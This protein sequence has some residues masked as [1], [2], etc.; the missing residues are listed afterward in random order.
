[1][2]TEDLA[3]VFRVPVR[4]AY[5]PTQAGLLAAFPHGGTALGA[6]TD[7]VLSQVLAE[8]IV[9]AWELG[10]AVGMLRGLELWRLACALEQDDPDA[11]AL[12]FTTASASAGYSGARTIQATSPGYVAATAL[13][14]IV[15]SPLDPRH[16]G[17]ILHAPIA[18]VGPPRRLELAHGRRCEIA[19]QFLCGVDAAGKAISIDRLE[20]ITL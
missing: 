6:I 9:T 5:A 13:S 12:L 7:V 16:R 11:I 18:E 3:Q 8:R 4:L 17:A 19:M 20:H 2:A 10:R 14:P 15:V 1:M